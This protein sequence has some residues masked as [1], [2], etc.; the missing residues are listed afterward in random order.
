MKNLINLFLIVFPVFV[1]GQNEDLKLWYQQPAAKWT[2][3]LPLGNGRL[4]AMVH[5]RV[6]QE[7]FQLNEESVWAGSKI[8]NNNKQSAAHLKEIQE[9]IFESRFDDAK[10]LATKYMVG[11]P[12]RIRS[13]QPLGNLRVLYPWSKSDSKDYSRTL[14]LNEGLHTTSFNI[15]GNKI[16]Q[17]SF[18]SAVDDA[19]FF[20]LE[21]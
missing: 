8:N 5:G 2:E 18:I 11:T 3:A 21:I 17:T 9:A 4:G 12:A 13:Y 14:L 10:E 1:F 6:D 15:N 16:D 19:L 20:R 7:L